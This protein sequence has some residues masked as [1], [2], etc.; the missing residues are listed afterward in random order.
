MLSSEWKLAGEVGEG[1]PAWSVSG[2]KCAKNG[3]LR[4][5]EPRL[6]SVS[7]TGE[8]AMESAIMSP[9]ERIVGA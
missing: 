6:S 7:K 1:S 8:T 5:V 9:W 4:S 3:L 2:R